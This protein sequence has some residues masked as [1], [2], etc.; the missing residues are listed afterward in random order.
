MLPLVS[1][2]VPIF[3]VEKWLRRCLDSLIEQTYSNLEF[4]LID[5]GATDNSGII[6]DEYAEIDKRI[7]VIHQDNLGVGAARN[8]GL[9]IAKGKYIGF[10]DPDDY[11]DKDMFRRLVMVAIEGSADIVMCNYYDV[12]I[13]GIRKGYYY[14]DDTLDTSQIKDKIMVNELPSFLWNKIFLKGLFKDIF[15]HVDIFEDFLLMPLIC[16]RARKIKCIDAYLYYYNRRNEFSLT[17]DAGFEREYAF[18][19]ACVEKR[20]LISCCEK[21]VVYLFESYVGKIALNILKNFSGGNDIRMGKIVIW[22]DGNYSSLRKRDKILYMLYKRC[23]VLFDLYV[24]YR[25]NK[26]S[27][28]Y[29]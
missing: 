12:E 16:S 11:V 19:E 4:I 6:C 21:R 24:W 3:Q 17:S 14:F 7:R 23:K 20:N 27:K 26:I 2:I 25:K 13:D 10:V 8:V 28:V 18:F 5:D 15:F 29:K 22:L 9:S 1:I